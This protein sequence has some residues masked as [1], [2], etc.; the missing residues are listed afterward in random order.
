MRGG[1]WGTLEGL[2]RNRAQLVF[3]WVSPP[4]HHVCEWVHTGT[5]PYFYSAI[6][7][8]D[9]S[10]EL[11]T[12]VWQ[13]PSYKTLHKGPVWVVWLIKPSTNQGRWQLHAPMNFSARSQ[14]ESKQ[15]ASC[16]TSACDL[17]WVDQSTLSNFLFLSPSNFM[18]GHEIWLSIIHHC[19]KQFFGDV[20]EIFFLFLLRQLFA[21]LLQ[22][23]FSWRSDLTL[24]WELNLSPQHQPTKNEANVLI[25]NVLTKRSRDILLYK[26]KSQWQQYIFG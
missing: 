8:A 11:N 18:A 4:L 1:G 17:S 6:F 10:E 26:A 20:C 19:R 15:P 3:N 22:H 23:T 21:H 25:C 13:Q 2:Q 14:H 16:L 5:H 24:E 7:S 12:S 9:G